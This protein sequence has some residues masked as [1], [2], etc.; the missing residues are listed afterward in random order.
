MAKSSTSQ[1]GGASRPASESSILVSYSYFEKDDIQVANMEFFTTV[2]MGMSSHFKSPK[3][4]DFVLVINGNACTPCKA[5]RLYKWHKRRSRIQGV[6]EVWSRNNIVMLYRRENEGMDFAAHNVSPL[7]TAYPGAC[8][9]HDLV[10][11][12]TDTFT[13]IDVGRII[14][15]GTPQGKPQ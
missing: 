5:L 9:R 13:F 7:V 4:T 1:N 12:I 3:N 15:D 11:A 2:G 8:V 6:S 14:L 10:L